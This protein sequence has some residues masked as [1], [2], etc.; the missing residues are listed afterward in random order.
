MNFRPS[1]KILIIKWF[2]FRGR[3]EL[4]LQFYIIFNYIILILLHKTKYVSEWINTTIWIKLYI[5]T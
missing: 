2:T 5:K 3:L 1:K 4:V